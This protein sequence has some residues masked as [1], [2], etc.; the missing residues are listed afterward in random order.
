MYCTYPPLFPFLSSLLYPLLGNRVTHFLPLLSFFLSFILLSRILRRLRTSVLMRYSMLFTFLL[1]SPIL[2]YSIT[3]WE[4]LPGVLMA[5]CSLYF[6]VR[7]FGADGAR[8]VGDLPVLSTR[9]QAAKRVC[10]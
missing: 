9:S 7:Y 10:F 3:F 6:V 8:T 4:H 1:G 2:T 5:M